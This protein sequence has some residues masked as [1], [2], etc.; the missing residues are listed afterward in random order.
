MSRERVRVLPSLLK[1]KVAKVML[2]LPPRVKR[3]F[4]EMAFHDN[5]KAHDHYLRAIA[6]YLRKKGH[7]QEANTLERKLRHSQSHG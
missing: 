7:D 5:C 4:D 1:E 2:Y 3:K 6:A